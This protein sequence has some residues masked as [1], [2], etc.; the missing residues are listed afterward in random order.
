MKYTIR[1]FPKTFSI[2]YGRKMRK[3]RLKLENKAKDLTNNLKTSSTESVVKEYEKCKAEL[4][5][6]YDH[7][8]QGIILRSKVTWYEKGGKS[9][10][11]F[12]ESGK[13]R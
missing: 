1:G 10:Q 2:E 3:N 11:Y 6:M 8:T 5:K 9:N 7:L 13:E 4:K 12:F